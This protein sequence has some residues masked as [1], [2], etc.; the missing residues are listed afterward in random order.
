MIK[1]LNQLKKALKNCPRLEIVGHCRPECI[2]QIRRVSLTNTR[3]FYTV[4]D[5]QPEHS[6]S[7]ANGGEGFSLS[8]GK[9][10]AWGFEDGICSIYERDAEHTP[11]HLIMAFRVLDAA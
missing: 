7:R 4:M 6:I 10:G 2:G 1:N 5:D 11:E 8:W 9:A 3:N